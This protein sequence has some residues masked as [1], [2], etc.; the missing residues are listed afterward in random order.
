MCEISG[1]S[2]QLINVEYLLL[3]DDYFY[4]DCFN[5]SHFSICLWGDSPYLI[6]L[7]TKKKKSSY[8]FRQAN[9]HVFNVL[10]SFRFYSRTFTLKQKQSIILY[11]TLCSWKWKGYLSLISMRME[12]Y[13]WNNIND[14]LDA[15]EIVAKQFQ[16]FFLSWMN[17]FI[18][19]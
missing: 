1:I 17:E 14:L 13:C 9:Y 4:I 6:I 7:H 8:I 5:N 3:I 19:I 16:W 2:F 11:Q 18:R 12:L 15:G 10:F